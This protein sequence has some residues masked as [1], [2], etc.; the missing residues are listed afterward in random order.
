MLRTTFVIATVVTAAA[1]AQPLHA[2]G[3]GTS[4]VAKINKDVV[5][6]LK[7]EDL[8]ARYAG[9]GSLAVSSTPDE[10]SARMKRESD[11]YR[12][13]IKAANIRPE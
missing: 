5:T 3:R 4:I 7:A 6:A 13:I 11:S 12:S 10:L 1:A 8:I 9:A 2:Q